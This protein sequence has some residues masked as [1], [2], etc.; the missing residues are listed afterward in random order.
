M[1]SSARF[2][3]LEGKAVGLVGELDPTSNQLI[4]QLNETPQL[5]SDFFIAIQQ[6][7]GELVAGGKGS[8]I[9][10]LLQR[11]TL[12]EEFTSPQVREIHDTCKL[13]LLTSFAAKAAA[14]AEAEAAAALAAAASPKGKGGGGG[15][16]KGGK[17][18]PKVEETPPPPVEIVPE[19]VPKRF[20]EFSGSE[21]KSQ[22]KA[23]G[24]ILL[25][26]AV[27][28]FE[29]GGKIN[30]FPVS[31]K[32]PY[33]NL[34]PNDFTEK[35]SDVPESTQA[36]EKAALSSPLLRVDFIRYIAA[37]I[38]LF[39]S[40]ND[41]FAAVF[42][43][44]KLFNF[45]TND[46][47][48]PEAFSEEFKPLKTVIFGILSSLV[49]VLERNANTKISFDNSQSTEPVEANPFSLQELKESML[50]LRDLLVYLLKVNWLQKDFQNVVT[51]GSRIFNLFHTL[52]P[53]YAKVY[54]DACLPLVVHSQEQLVAFAQSKLDEAIRN[55]EDF[56]FQYEEAQKKKRKKKLR[57]ARTE[58]D[59]EELLFDAQT[60]ELQGK[61]NEAEDYLL[62][63]KRELDLANSMKKTFETMNSQGSQMLDKA[64]QL[65]TS[66]LISVKN[67]YGNDVDYKSLL[68]DAQIRH[69]YEQ[70]MK[71]LSHVVNF[72]R[73]KKD[74]VVLVEALKCQSDLMLL[75]GDI[76]EARKLLHDLIDG[77]FNSIDACVEWLKVCERALASLEG[78]LVACIIPSIAALGK[79]SKF[80]ASSDWDAKAGYCRMAAEL[81]KIPFSESVGH[82]SVHEALILQM[83]F[84]FTFYYIDRFVS[85]SLK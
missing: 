23:F 43:S 48:D 75:F 82:P 31:S 69:K 85:E 64:R 72:L 84:C 53:E 2:K 24:S 13:K 17:N 15:A 41:L 22:T 71:N 39:S 67:E 38:Q 51:I 8:E 70:I 6:L 46:W 7:C 9:P 49:E 35:H 30:Q 65:Y 1:D 27:S 16:A 42:A 47:I 45:V 33:E 44:V 61:I 81:I 58:K 80:C 10:V 63:R 32:G 4:Q 21:I 73:E 50:Q 59:E 60:A 11:C 5:Q 76:G 3:L 68:E 18:A 14:A 34:D 29:V 37:S 66:L 62:E 28:S 52:C 83:D 57:V 19:E 54:G 74:R 56:I 79:L 36:D 78:D 20:A 40:S 25:Y 12:F 55:K 77:L 26:F